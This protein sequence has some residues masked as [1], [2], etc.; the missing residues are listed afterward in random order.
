MMLKSMINPYKNKLNEKP[1]QAHNRVSLPIEAPFRFLGLFLILLFIASVSMTIITI[2]DSLID[3]KMTKILNNF[4]EYSLNYGFAID[5]II[6]EGREK[7][8]KE[9]LIEKIGLTRD[10]NILDT[11]LHKIKKNIEELPWIE[12]ADVKRT[13]FPNTLQIKLYEKDVLALWQNEGKFHP[14]DMKGKIIDAEYIAHKPILV[15]TGEKAPENI[16]NLLDITSKNPEFHKRIVAAV[17]YSGRR[18]NLIFDNF[19]NGITVKLPQKNVE[20]AW[21]KFVKINNQYAVLN[22]KLTFIDLRYKDKVSVTL[23]NAEDN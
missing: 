5:D 11:D 13:Y 18:W 20:Q 4:Y 1:L 21:K 10:N 19:E 17:F 7:T 14:L 8:K 9:D 23:S 15:I 12:T 2:R 3:K 22:R 16:L 6:I